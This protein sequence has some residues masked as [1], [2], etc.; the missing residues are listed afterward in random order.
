METIKDLTMADPRR[1]SGHG[2]H[3]FL[4][5]TLA[6][7]TESER[8]NFSL[9]FPNLCYNCFEKLVS[10]IRKCCQLQRDFVLWPPDQYMLA[11]TWSTLVTRSTCSL[12]F[13]K[14]RDYNYCSEISLW[15]YKVS[16]SQRDF[17]PLTH[18]PLY[19]GIDMLTHSPC[20]LNIP[21]LCD[22]LVSE[23]RKCRRRQRD[24]SLWLPDH[25]M[26]VQTL[27]M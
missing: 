24:L 18:W 1:K 25:Y 4:L 6:P 15:N 26:L 20:S 3:P 21:N 9:N 17:V 14:S 22:N 7:S 23:I 27:A 19:A 13:S 11:Q 5:W 8:K 16:S 12:N 10:E 2:L